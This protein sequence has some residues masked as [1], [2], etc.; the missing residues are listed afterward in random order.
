MNS[1][2]SLTG[3]HLRT[4]EAIFRHPA[5]HNLAWRDVRALLA[6]LG[7]VADEANGHLKVTRHGHS[8]ILHSPHT[9]EITERST[10]TELRRFIEQSEKPAAPADGPDGHWLVVINHHEA[11]VYR[12]V[13]HG[14]VPLQVLPHAPEAFFRHTAHSKDFSRGQEKPDPATFFGP[15]AAALG[16]AG[17]IVVFGSGKGTGSEM[18]QFIAWAKQH[19][20]ALAAR[21]IGSVVIDQ[22]HTTPA[23]LLAKAREFYATVPPSLLR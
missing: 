4:Y 20:P 8:L 16:A 19:H 18:E 17:K 21:I 2:T 9:K 15:V 7:Q 3:S 23:Q 14:N 6:E 13:I 1:T 22:H 11:L 12:S 5:P 10:L